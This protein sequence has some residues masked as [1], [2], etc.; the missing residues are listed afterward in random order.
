M[1]PIS[2]QEKVLANLRKELEDLEKTISQKTYI[3]QKRL[4]QKLKKDIEIIISLKAFT[5]ENMQELKTI[6]QHAIDLSKEL[7][8]DTSTRFKRP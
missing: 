3:T 6:H 7:N 2:H 8:L 1:L 5:K 4:I